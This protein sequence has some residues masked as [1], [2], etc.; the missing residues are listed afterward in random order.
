MLVCATL[1][2]VWGAD[3]LALWYE[4]TA[5]KQD[6]RALV[7][8]TVYALRSQVVFCVPPSGRAAY[9]AHE[10]DRAPSMISDSVGIDISI[11]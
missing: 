3:R 11:E 7:F 10:A 6:T 1:E 4:R 8:S 9:L 2:R 5:A